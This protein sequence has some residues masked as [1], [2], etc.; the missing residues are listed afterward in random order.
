MKKVIA[1]LAGAIF[2]I[3][4]T[5][6]NTGSGIS[7]TRD[8]EDK[9]YR[10]EDLSKI[11]IDPDRSTINQLQSE[12]SSEGIAAG[13]IRDDDTDNLKSESGDDEGSV[14]QKF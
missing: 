10:D 3:A 11:K 14:E 2:A 13:G 5:F 9:V 4:L 8:L 1:F 6:V 7:E 12:Q